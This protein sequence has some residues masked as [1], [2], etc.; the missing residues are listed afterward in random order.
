MT[1]KI[2][3]EKGRV[4]SD[5]IMQAAE[6]LK[7]GGIGIVPTDTVYGIV[8]L[9][10]NPDSLMRVYELKKRPLSKPLP[11]QVSSVEHASEI[12]VI[13]GDICTKLIERFWPGALTIVLFRKPETK[14][15]LQPDDKIGLRMPDYPLALELIKNSGFLVAPS[16]NFSG[17]PAPKEFGEI[18]PRLFE[19]VDFVIDAGICP[20][21]IES[22]VVDVTGGIKILR[23]GAI[24]KEMIMS[25]VQSEEN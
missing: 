19:L 4:S 13:Q 17:E 15:A 21:G 25:V 16:A 23:E 20:K 3:A 1:I 24:T 11:I 8:A 5:E 6:I 10:T 18:N 7:S 2:V 12:A 14:L 22:T 9:A